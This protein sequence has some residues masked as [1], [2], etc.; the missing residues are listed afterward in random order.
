MK[1]EA[2][3][4]YWLVVSLF[5]LAVLLAIAA[6][7]LWVVFPRGYFTG[8][9]IWVEIH[10]WTGLILAIAVIAHIALHR[11]WLVQMTRRYT[12]RLRKKRD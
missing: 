12:D 11:K 4:R 2:T 6:F 8:R 5:V 10:R 7:L 9:A 3:I 1:N